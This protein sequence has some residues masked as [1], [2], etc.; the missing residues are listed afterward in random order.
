MTDVRRRVVAT[1]VIGAMLVVLAPAS[2]SAIVHSGQVPRTL[3]EPTS[4]APETTEPQTTGPE[5]TTPATTEPESTEPGSS[6]P[7]DD[8]DLTAVSI[9]GVM[10][11]ALLVILAGWWMVQRDDD[12]DAPHPRPPNLDE[13][14]PGQDLI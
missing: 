8:A 7:D 1:C 14:L 12:D 2:S 5:T 9:V 11:F 10:A 4:T 3:D 13:P 6:Q